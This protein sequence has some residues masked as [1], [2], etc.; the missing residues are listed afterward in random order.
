MKK[1]ADRTRIMCAAVLLLLLLL[2]ACGKNPPAE[3][4]PAPETAKTTEAPAAETTRAAA[5]ST[6]APAETGT[7]EETT[8][9]EPTTTEPEPTTEAGP[10]SLE[11]VLATFNIKHG[12]EGLENVAAAIRDVSPDII[13]L[14]EVD[15]FGERSGYV[16][17]VQ[18]LAWQVD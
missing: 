15:V 5:E 8:V 6:A 9:P 7:E 4:T 17:E 13:G 1:R 11:I 16:D 12:A 14:Q 18:E 2:C 10:V 3:S